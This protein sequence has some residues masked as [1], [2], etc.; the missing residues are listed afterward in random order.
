MK[1]L[2]SLF[3]ICLFFICVNANA[4]S[5]V[6]NNYGD[7][8]SKN[9]SLSSSLASSTQVVTNT[10]DDTPCM[11]AVFGTYANYDKN[12]WGA[13][14]LMI[15]DQSLGLDVG[16]RYQNISKYQDFMWLSFGL[17]YSLNIVD[18][19]DTKVFLVGSFDLG[20]DFADVPN[21]KFTGS[22]FKIFLDA[23]LTPR[24]VMKLNHFALYAGYSWTAHKFKFK[25]YSVQDGFT[26]G[27]GYAF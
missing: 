17:N 3:T 11:N 27:V 4:Q 21:E 12:A 13:E 22:D 24:L 14:A 26:L 2:F 19:N 8:K 16:F 23:I 15:N 20:V 1:H 25:K 9:L 7:D 18:K 6:R 5:V 10:N